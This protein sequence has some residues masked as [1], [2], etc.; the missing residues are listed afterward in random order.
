MKLKTQLLL[1]VNAL[2]IS[3]MAGVFFVHIQEHEKKLEDLRTEMR[4]EV[5]IAVRQ[6][7]LAYQEAQNAILR[8]D[9]LKQR[10]CLAANIYH[11][12]GIETDDGKRGVAWVT[13]NRVVNQKYPDTICEVVYQARTDVDGDPLKNECQFSWYCDGKGD[14]IK[15]M[16][17]WNRSLQ[18]ATEVM[19][20]YGKTPD[21]TSGAIM[22][23]ADYVDP[24]WVASYQETTKIDTHLFYK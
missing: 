1:G 20:S 3:S 22:Y 8:V 14:D 10:D 23:H 6:A 12:A 19:T 4:A 17:T 18:I 13:M 9:Y 16:S 15:S 11:E 5:D 21:P 24:F 2:V 7:D